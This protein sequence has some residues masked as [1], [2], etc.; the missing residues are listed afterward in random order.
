MLVLRC[1]KLFPPANGRLE[2]TACGNVYGS[3]CRL[4]CY[5]GH[6]LKG[7]VERMC[8]KKAGTNEVYWTGNDTSCEG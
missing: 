4:A 1:S 5:K 8:D 6:E 7:S 3:I 2:N